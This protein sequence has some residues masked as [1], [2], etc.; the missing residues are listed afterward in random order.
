MT[1]TEAL[2][3]LFSRWEKRQDSEPDDLWKVT[4]GGNANISRSHF[5]R[6]GIIDEPTFEKERIKVLFISNE[7]ND[8]QYSAA[9]RTRTDTVRDFREYHLTGRDDWKGM[10]RLR[11]SA[12]Y[13]V[14]TGQDPDVMTDS[15]AA[16]HYAVMDL[17]KRG[18]GSDIHGGSHLKAYCLE[19]RDFIRREIDIIDPD[20]IAWLSIAS[21]Q[22]DIPESC[23]GAY[24][25]R[26]RKYLRLESGKVCPIL[27]LWHTSYIGSSIEPLEGYRDIRVGRQAA[28][29]LLEMERYGLIERTGRKGLPDTDSSRKESEKKD[30]LPGQMPSEEDPCSSSGSP[31]KGK[32]DARS[33]SSVLGE[34][35]EDLFVLLEKTRKYIRSLGPEVA[36]KENGRYYSYKARRVFAVVIP[37]RTRV[38]INL[39]TDPAAV[40]TDGFFS[41]D[42]KGKQSYGSG[43]L[44]LQLFVRDEDQYRKARILIDR[45][46]RENR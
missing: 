16:L 33:V 4:N 32:A 26:G 7:A 29:C 24:G 31:G 34:M 30:P 43:S 9:S 18:G 19:Y 45:A 44:Q 25:E 12:L 13:K 27:G 1:K 3:E 8:D 39:R 42:L 23:L 20:I 10:M 40:E 2:K 6:D 28:K 22:S 17:N 5:R 36:E 14:I 37:D 35:P 46:C 41:R 15:E 11:V 38:I 21:F